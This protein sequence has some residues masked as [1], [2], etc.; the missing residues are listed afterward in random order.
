MNSVLKK[1]AVGEG[2]GDKRQSH[3]VL[4]GDVKEIRAYPTSSWGLGKSVQSVLRKG[5]REG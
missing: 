5:D 2:K 3:N 1:G 4:L